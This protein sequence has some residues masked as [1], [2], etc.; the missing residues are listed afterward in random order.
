MSDYMSDYDGSVDGGYEWSD[1][2]DYE[3][4]YEDGCDDC[5]DFQESDDEHSFYHD[6]ESL[7]NGFD[8]EDIVVLF[9]SFSEDGDRHN[10]FV[11]GDH[12]CYDSDDD[13]DDSSE[14]QQ[15]DVNFNENY[16]GC[17][18]E[19]EKLELEL[20]LESMVKASYSIQDLTFSG[21]DIDISNF[22]H[23]S[24]PLK[25]SFTNLIVAK[26]PNDDVIVVSPGSNINGVLLSSNA[27]GDS[28]PTTAPVDPIT[29]SSHVKQLV[30]N[31]S[32]L[33]SVYACRSRESFKISSVLS[34]LHQFELGRDPPYVLDIGD[35]R[36]GFG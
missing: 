13:N 17:I 29:Y 21:S 14:S 25:V 11:V 33:P 9:D 31:L 27:I 34:L 32:T 2:G 5:S 18:D 1:D 20:W 16:Y 24:S 36:F 10:A 7:N 12:G 6:D 28:L 4:S 3:W 23:D 35:S 8:I 30:C 22:L 26:E 15:E 19:S